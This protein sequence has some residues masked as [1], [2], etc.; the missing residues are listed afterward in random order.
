M[1]KPRGD[2][3][4]EKPSLPP[5]VYVFWEFDGENWFLMCYQTAEE[6]TTS[7][8]DNVEVDVGHYKI[9]HTGVVST[10]VVYI[11]TKGGNE[12]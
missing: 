3:R 2:K 8:N 12:K 5:E 1:T 9:A 4:P 7:Y 11:E 6:C 10:K